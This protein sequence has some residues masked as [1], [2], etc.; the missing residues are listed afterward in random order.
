MYFNKAI[1]VLLT[2]AVMFLSGCSLL[3]LKIDSQTTPLTQQELNMR[4]LTREYAQQFFIKVE[5]AA[6]EVAASYPPEDTLHQSY[7][8]LWKI[9][10]HQGLQSAAYQSSPMAGLIET[11]VFTY[12]MRDFFESDQGKVLFDSALPLEA[13]EQLVAQIDELAKAIL[14]SSAF[15]SSQSFV[16]EF[17]KANPFVDLSF[18]RTPA[19][20]AWLEANNIS[21]DEAVTTMGTM[22]EALGDISDRLSL[23]SEQT[24]KLMKWKAQVVALNSTLSGEQ[25]TQTLESLQRTSIA[26]QDFIVNNPEYME[27]L[28]AQMAVKLQPLVNDI[29]AKTGDR[30]Q[31]LGTE[32][33]AL[34]DMVAR[35]RVELI[36]MIERERT[37]LS[38]IVSHERRQFTSEMDQLSQDVVSLAMDKLVEL[39][40]STVIYFVLFILVIFFA[41]LLLGY[42]LGKRSANKS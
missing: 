41:P 33:Q 19:Y 36:N 30:L 31:Q 37:A 1:G 4:V 3:E 38:E 23:V 26:L 11:W 2:F 17:S 35:E 7:T 8:L 21:I 20:M 10:A 18:M 24:P 22:P 6:D 40:K 28:A 5:Q 13:S 39:I 42:A 9:N 25:L 12:Q 15:S 14:K 32:R 34:E 16:V 27:N 29:D